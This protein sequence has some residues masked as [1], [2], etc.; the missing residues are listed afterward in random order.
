MNAAELDAIRKRDEVAADTWFKP[1]GAKGFGACGQAFI[2]RRALLAE[3]DAALERGRALT[4]NGGHAHHC[5]S[6]Y[7][8]GCDCGYA[9]VREW[10][11]EW[12]RETQK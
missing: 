5:M 2:D 11:R 3:L 12:Q 4:V 8:A 9:A 1:V 6:W 10:Q 7:D